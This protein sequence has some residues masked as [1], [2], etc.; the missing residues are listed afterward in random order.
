MNLNKLKLYLETMHAKQ[1]TFVI[2]WVIIL[3]PH[4]LHCKQMRQLMQLKK[5]I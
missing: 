5:H 2:N 1:E 4:I 3:K